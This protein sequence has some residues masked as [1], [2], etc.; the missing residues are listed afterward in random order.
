[1][2]KSLTYLFVLTILI[3]GCK[4]EE[5]IDFDKLNLS[6][7]FTYYVNSNSTVELD[8][9]EQRMYDSILINP[10]RFFYPIVKID[11]N[12]NEV[13]LQF[14]IS[15]PDYCD[16]SIKERNVFSFEIN[17]HDTI[18]AEGQ[19]ITNLDSLDYDIREYLTNPQNKEH[20]PEKTI[21]VIEYFDT[22]LVTKSAFGI[23]AQTLPDSLDNK[24]SWKEIKNIINRI[25]KSTYSLRNEIS[26]SKWNKN[27]EKLKLKQKVAVCDYLPIMIWIYPHRELNP[28]P[29]PPPPMSQEVIGII[30]SSEIDDESILDENE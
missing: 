6:E 22:V 28:P 9:I 7:L 12:R 27:Y 17:R 5:K 14:G 10:Y 11:S 29:P 1:M 23:S 20:L 15:Q 26:L 30:E 21:E 3:I 19:V 18:K 16:Y 24:T 4:P 25:E 8:S 13:L 2:K